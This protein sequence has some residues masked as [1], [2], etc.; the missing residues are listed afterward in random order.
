[1][2]RTPRGRG[3]GGNKQCYPFDEKPRAVARPPQGTTRKK[4]HT[5]CIIT[6]CPTSSLNI[7]YDP[8][9][10]R[11]TPSENTR[12]QS[13][14][15]RASC[16]QR[17]AALQNSKP[18]SKSLSSSKISGP[19]GGKDTQLYSY[20]VQLTRTPK[21]RQNMHSQGGGVCSV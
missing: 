2:K 20:S 15:V 6:I 4:T 5:H 8:H 21:K 3:E 18:T 16:V 9:V 1:M 10:S 12:R 13:I 7:P 19:R 11:V 17:R 14:A